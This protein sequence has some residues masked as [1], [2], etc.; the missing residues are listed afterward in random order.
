MNAIVVGVKFIELL[1]SSGQILIWV[2]ECNNSVEFGA[3]DSS[4]LVLIKRSK[5]SNCGKFDFIRVVWALLVKESLH[6][7]IAVGSIIRYVDN[8]VRVV[9][10]VLKGSDLPI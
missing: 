10:T 8:W 1:K 9:V 5:V 7:S 4:I 6:I 3:G 2:Q